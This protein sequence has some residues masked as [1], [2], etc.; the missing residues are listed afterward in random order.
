[1]AFKSPE[2][3]RQMASE[4]A[5]IRVQFVDHDV[6]EVFEQPHPFCMVRQDPGMQ[7]V[8]ICQDDV[9]ALA[10]CPSSVAW[11]VTVIGENSKSVVEYAREVLQFS[12]LVLR[13]RFGGKQIHRPRIRIFEDCIQDG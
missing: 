4:Y 10:N 5:A 2:Y 1:D 12:Q 8:G 13:Q 6:A 9:S 11:S 7:H 3:I